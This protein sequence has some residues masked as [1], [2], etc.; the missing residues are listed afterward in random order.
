MSDGNLD[1]K[2][3]LTTAA[4]ASAG[5]VTGF[6]AI[7]PSRAFAADTLRV[8][9]NEEY[10]GVYAA[11]AQSETRG[12]LMAMDAWNARGG[13]MGGTKVELVQADN[14]NNPG[15]SVEKTRQLVLVQKCPV[16]MG[17]INSADSL[18]VSGAANALNTFFIDS[19]GHADA[20]TGA[21]CEYSS[22]RTCHS[23]WM[24]T[25]ATGY[26]LAKKFG[27]KWYMIIPDYAFGHALQAGYHAVG[28]Q[29]GVEFVGEDLT[30][31]GTT[32]FSPYLTKVLAAKP[33][34]LLVLVQGDDFVNCL[35]QTTQYGIVGKVPIGGPQ[36][37]LEAVWALPKEARVGYW[38]VEWYYKGA[39]VIGSGNKLIDGF[40]SEYHR[41]YG[42]PPTAR[43]AF[44]YITMDRMLWTVN[45]AKTTNAAKMA[46]TLEGAKFRSLWDGEGYYRDVDHQLMWPMWVGEIRAQ[47]TAEDKY[48][49]FDIVDRQEA[50]KI[51]QSVAEKKAVCHMNWPT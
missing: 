16:L 40:I 19:G 23:T 34:L 26:S 12:A 25:H 5:L 42:Q 33:D 51:E 48:D 18:A 17:T 50:D 29:I 13:V 8:G 49:I 6:P 30:P 27:K 45:E 44:G 28:K 21:K 35:K 24:E 2:S 11:Y 7:L 1:R 9:L 15:T 14:N 3:F 37:E 4:I 22:F 43:S 10:T 31:L 38:G 36:V 20:V 47:G 32:D 39:S 46:K 41:K